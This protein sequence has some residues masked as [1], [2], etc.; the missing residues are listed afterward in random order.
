MDLVVAC[1]QVIRGLPS[2]E[3][4][5][6]ASQIRRAAV[7][8]P[9]NIAEGHGRNHTREYLQHIAVAYAS[10]MELETHIQISE[11]LEMIE[12][13]VARNVLAQADRVGKM[14]SGLKKALRQRRP[15]P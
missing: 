5:G 6:L 7:S 8:V 3:H 4:F 12:P 9:A 13:N 14:L 11:R 10:L 15:K 2:S 1:Y